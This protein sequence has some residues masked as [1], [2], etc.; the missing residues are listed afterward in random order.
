MKVILQKDVPNLGDA[1][2]LKDVSDGYA[3]NFLIPRKLVIVAKAG[4]TRALEHQ[5]KLVQVKIEQRTR[6]MEKLADDMKEIQEL[7]IPVN[8]GAKGKLFGSVT[9]HVIAQ[10]LE[11]KGYSIDKRK[12]D[13]EKPIRSLGDY[14]LKIRLADKIHVPVVVKIVPNE[15][16]QAAMEEE[17]AR[18]QAIAA[19][20]AVAAGL[21]PPSALQTEEVETASSQEV[22]M[23]APDSPDDS[24]DLDTADDTTTEEP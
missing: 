12:V 2:D 22:A 1:G 13:L 10:A 16:S 3:R 24:E 20:D 17:E 6:A 14:N 23:E 21:T 5:K 8:V 15:E 9:G 18:V 7:I 11:E 19:R 4:S